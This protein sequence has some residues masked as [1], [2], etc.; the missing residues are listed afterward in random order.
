MALPW[1][2]KRPTG[3]HYE[4]SSSLAAGATPCTTGEAIRR[5][6]RSTAIVR[7]TIRPGRKPS[8]PPR[9][10]PS[11]RAQPSARIARQDTLGGKQRGTPQK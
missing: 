4:T 10:F 11:T 7:L 3:G 1:R 9:V 2:P 5:G 6:C 8:R